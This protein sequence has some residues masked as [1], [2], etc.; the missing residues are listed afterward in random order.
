MDILSITYFIK[1]HHIFNK[2]KTS[3]CHTWSKKGNDSK[4]KLLFFGV[5]HLKVLFYKAFST[6]KNNF[7]AFPYPA[8]YNFH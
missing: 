4:V 7:E 5:N 2:K 8:S 3:G 6:P 1:N